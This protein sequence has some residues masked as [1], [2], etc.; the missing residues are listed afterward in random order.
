MLNILNKTKQTKRGEIMITK[1]RQKLKKNVQKI[2][3]AGEKITNI[4]LP[5]GKF[6]AECILGM[7]LSGS[8]NLTEIARQ[9]KEG[10]LIKYTLKRLQRMASWHNILEIANKICL[11]LVSKE[12]TKET[13][14]VLDGGDIAHLYGSK[15]ENMCTVRDGSTG[16]YAKGYHLNQIVGY[17]PSTNT[18]FPVLVEMYSSV[19]DDFESANKEAFKI[20]RDTVSSVGTKPLWVMDRNY[21]DIKYFGLMEE[22]GCSFMIRMKVNRNVLIKGESKNIFEVASKINRRYKYK[23]YG[24]YGT[25]KVLLKVPVNGKSVEKEFTLIA[26]K[27]RKNKEISFYLTSGYIRSK[28]EIK[29]RLKG[30]FKRWSVEECYRFEKQGFGIEKALVRNFTSIQSLLGISL[31]SWLVLFFV[32]QDERLKLEVLHSAKMEKTKN[33][34]LPKFLYYRLLK[35]I[36]LLFEGTKRLLNFRKT[37]KQRLIARYERTH[38]PIMFIEPVWLEV[39]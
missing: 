13:V 4:S 20:I 7:I 16:K 34:D 35:G 1:N 30:Y 36:Q 8:S 29:R 14:L 6:I 27:G 2:V 32:H 23:N 12:I 21:D 9:L 11:H 33:K 38:R 5:V 37:K 18:T 26:F 24:K 10:T 3:N 17:N 28:K 22:L 15:F 39:G 19:S 25:Q 31:L